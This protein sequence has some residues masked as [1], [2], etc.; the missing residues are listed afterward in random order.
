MGDA[1]PEDTK[2][3]DSSGSAALAAEE[4]HSSNSDMEH[5]EQEEAEM[6][7]EEAGVEVGG[8]KGEEEEEVDELQTSVLSVLGGERDVDIQ[9]PQTQ[10]LLVSAEDP[11]IEAEIVEFMQVVPPMALPPLPVLTLDPPSS[12]STPI[13]STTTCEAEELY[14][15]PQGL[16]PP[17]ILVP[18]NPTVESAAL[19]DVKLSQISPKHSVLA[20]Q[21]TTQE[22]DHTKPKPAK[23]LSSTDL[24]ILLCGSAALVAVVGVVAYG[25]VAY[26]RK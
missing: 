25:A 9:A 13:P 22:R 26:C 3:L 5:L 2:S 21:V 18:M 10:E 7:E 16:H 24:P 4:N 17:S 6:L 11:H 23:G 12:T 19:D 20:S 15:T 8:R 14:S 1:D